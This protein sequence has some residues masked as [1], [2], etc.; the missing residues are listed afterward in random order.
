MKILNVISSINPSG[1]GPVENLKQSGYCLEE[2]GHTVEVASLD[3]PKSQYIEDFPLTLHALGPSF[4]SYRYSKYLVP[5]LKLNAHHYDC[6]IV[7]GI[8][9]YSGFGVWRALKW[10]EHNQDPKPPYFVFTHGMLDPWFKQTYPLKHLKKWL[11][12]PWAEY[13]VLRDAKAVL[14][15]CE[16]EKILARQSFGLYKCNEIVVNYGTA[17]P[18]VGV[19]QQI[20]CYLEQFPEL[21]SKRI[22]LFLSRIHPK[23]GCDILIK[24]FSKI[25]QT[26]SNLHLVIAGPDQ[27]G[28]QSNLKNLAQQLN[29]AQKITWTGML[30]GD[31]KWGAFRAAEVFILPSHQENFGIVVAEALACRL[32]VLISNKV[33][34]WRE[35]VEDQ[36]GFVEED[37]YDGTVRLFQEWIELLSCQRDIM[38]LNAENCF[39]KRFQINRAALNLTAILENTVFDVHQKKI[40]SS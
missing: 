37:T 8:W 17:P 32:P 34:I 35:I 22:I 3:A 40:P 6:I 21:R 28:W 13:R 20:Q 12:W 25:S 29:I 26:D 11:Y 27:T 39:T 19:N 2:L 7:R 36:A 16:E 1:G 5:W 31:L 14:F 24:A 9:Q 10:L 38:S 33:N 15:T 23:K 30:Q 4:T 18:P